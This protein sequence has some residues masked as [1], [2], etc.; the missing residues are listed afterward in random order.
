MPFYRSLTR[1]YN[2]NMV[3]NKIS[4]R[5]ILKSLGVLFLATGC[6]S[7]LTAL[8]KD[9][10]AAPLPTPTPTPLPSADAVVQ[11]YLDA[12]NNGDYEAMYYLLTPNSQLHVNRADFENH[13]NR[14]LTTAT[15]NQIDTQIQSLLHQDSQAAATFASTWQTKLFGPIE[16]NNQMNLKFVEGRWGVEWQ[17]TQTE[18]VGPDAVRTRRPPSADSI[19]PKAKR[20]TTADRP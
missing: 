11:A 4:R 1:C 8:T 14:A 20:S 10:T 3:S 9:P 5:A 16:A 17:L 2:F 18:D 15:V 19:I 7:D 6:T 12:W 13:Y